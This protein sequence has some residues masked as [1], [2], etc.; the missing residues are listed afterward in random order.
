MATAAMDR[1]VRVW[2]IRNGQKCLRE[3]VMPYAA[4]GALTFSDRRML[5]AVVGG[6]TV[7]FYRDVCT[8]AVDYPY[9]RHKVHR[10]V[11]DLHFVPFEDVAGVGHADGFSRYDQ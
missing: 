1:T 7:E 2:D 10:K 3:M 9:M 4:A 11:T 8:K 5:G 6:D